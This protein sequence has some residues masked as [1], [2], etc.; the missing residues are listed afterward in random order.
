M[1]E[2]L[3]FVLLKEF[4]FIN[5]FGDVIFDKIVMEMYYIKWFVKFD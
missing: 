5:V 3:F 2:L 1:V 4:F